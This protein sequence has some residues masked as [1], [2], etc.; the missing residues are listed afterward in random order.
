LPKGYVIYGTSTLVYTT[1]HGV[2]GF[3]IKSGNGTFYLH[4]NMKFS[5]DGIYSIN[6]GNCSFSTR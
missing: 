1:G 5:K 3:Y 6:E 2:N 4:P